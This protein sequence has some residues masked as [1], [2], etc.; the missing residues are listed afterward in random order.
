MEQAAPVTAE[1][2]RFYRHWFMAAAV[3]NLL[4]GAMV[5]IWPLLPFRL[6]GIPDP[7]YPAL[8]ACIGMMVLVY[9]P[10]YYLVA[11]DPD[12]YAAFAWIGLAG[13][14]LGPLGFL[15]AA[16][17]GDLPWRF[18]LV[19]LTNDLIWWPVFWAFCLRYGREPF[20]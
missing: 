4:W 13:K 7:N 16:I 10:G 5:S 1:A 18:G 6:L 3:Y 2:P 19:L 8:F 9:A 14:T 15:I 11:R 20:R 17:N 12:R